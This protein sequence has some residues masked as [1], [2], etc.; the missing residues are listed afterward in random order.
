MRLVISVGESSG[1][2]LAAHLVKQLKSSHPNLEIAGIAGPLMV[3]QGVSAWFDM[4]ELNVMGLQEVITHLPRL[5][6]LRNN[7]RQRILD[8]QPDAFIGVDAPDFNLGL[9]R[10]VRKHGVLAFHYVSPSIWAWRAKRARKIARSIDGL[11]TLFPF[12][13]PLYEPYGLKTRCVG[14]PLADDI[15][16]A[17]KTQ[18]KNLSDQTTS[19]A[20]LPGS[21]SGEIERHMTL[22]LDTASKIQKTKPQTHWV[23]PVISMDQQVRIHSQWGQQLDQLNI[24]LVAG[25]TRSVLKEADLA[26]TA[27]GTV[28][29]EAFLLGCPQ[30]VYYRLAPATHWLATKLNLVKSQW[31]SLPNILTQSECVPE[32]IQQ[33]ATPEAISEAALSWLN[34]PERVQ[35]YRKVA[36]HMRETLHAGDQ[37]AQTIV[38]WIQAA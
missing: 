2:Y 32:Y 16:Y 7:F 23:M 28:T 29:L 21:R 20:L 22:L 38:E 36:Q 3:E 37:A 25:D 14:H 31:V 35:E 19:I 5:M 11:L 12:E 30:V 27:S 15:E 6:R 18:N 1:D 13:P 24:R 4:N 8:R 9:A 26:I 34:N 10:S 33:D 17:L